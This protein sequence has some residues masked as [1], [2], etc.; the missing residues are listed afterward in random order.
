MEKSSMI[1]KALILY[2]VLAILFAMTF[3]KWDLYI[4]N[5]D[6]G[7]PGFRS[8]YGAITMAGP[9]AY[10]FGCVFTLLALFIGLI[11]IR[12]RPF[13]PAGLLLFS[14]AWSTL[15]T[16]CF[17]YRSAG[18]HILGAL[19]ML[20]ELTVGILLLRLALKTKKPEK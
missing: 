5:T 16:L 14:G 9:S 1:K 11:T 3:L 15:H 6:N 12:C 7:S 20:G 4:Y 2:L 13:V 10:E 19:I 18:L 17:G 8:F